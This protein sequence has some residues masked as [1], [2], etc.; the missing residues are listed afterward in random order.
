M[1][2]D[3][4]KDAWGSILNLT[5]EEKSTLRN[6]DDVD[7]IRLAKG[8]QG[9]KVRPPSEKEL[10]LLTSNDNF[11]ARIQDI[12]RLVEQTDESSVRRAI[13]G[14]KVF[15]LLADTDSPAYQLYTALG[16]AK[17]QFAKATLGSQISDFDVRTWQPAFEGIPL[18]DSKQALLNRL[19]DIEKNLDRSKLNTLNNMRKG[20]ANIDRFEEDRR[21][22]EDSLASA[23]QMP[24]LASFIAEAKARGLSKEQAKAAWIALGGE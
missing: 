12:K 20:Y 19:T 14:G 18:L 13:K 24:D 6:V 1:L 23:S 17:Q 3:S 16:T 21:K 7:R 10:T 15:S 11:K 5:P 9:E 8:S 22:A 4:E 2:Q